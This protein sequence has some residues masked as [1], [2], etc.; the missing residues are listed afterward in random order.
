M[1]T[2]LGRKGDSE[3][4]TCT[5]CGRRAVS[6]GI[7]AKSSNVI[8]WVC[9]EPDC[10]TLGAKVYRMTQRQLD[11]YERKAIEAAAASIA[12]ATVE[13]VLGAIYDTGVRNL[14]DLDGTK[15]KMIVTALGADNGFRAVMGV[16]LVKYGEAVREEIKTGVPF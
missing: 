10:T 16:F 3:P 4:L 11:G 7:C 6:L 14:D 15:F 1:T 8:A 5:V 12:D 9:D 13:A 2:I